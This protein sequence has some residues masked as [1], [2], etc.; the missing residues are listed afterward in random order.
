VPYLN[1]DTDITHTAVDREKF[2]AFV[3]VRYLQNVKYKN[4][5]CTNIWVRL[6]F[7]RV[8]EYCNRLVKFDME[9]SY[10]HSNTLYDK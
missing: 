4:G 7:V 3:K 1:A 5:Y 9:V 2:A 6:F 10:V 8:M